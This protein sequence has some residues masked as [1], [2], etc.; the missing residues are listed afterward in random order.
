VEVVDM[1]AAGTT[2]ALSDDVKTAF[3]TFIASRVGGSSPGTTSSS[4][5]TG[6][7]RVL[8]VGDASMMLL[9]GA[10][11]VDV[12]TMS[13]GAAAS[14]LPVLQPSSFDAVVLTSG[15]ESL[16]D[17]RDV[18]RRLWQVLKPGG[19]CLACFSGAPYTPVAKSMKM[20]TTM[21]DEQ[22]IWIAGSYYQYSAGEGWENIEG[23]DLL[24]STGGASMVFDADKKKNVEGAAYVVTAQKIQIPTMGSPDFAAYNYTKGSLSGLTADMDADDRDF[25]AYRVAAE[26]ERKPADLERQRLLTSVGKLPTI[27]NILKEVKNIVIPAPV[28]AMLAVFLLE[29]WE[30]TSVQR[31]ALR[32][33]LGIDKPDDYWAALSQS[34]NAMPPREKILLLSDIIPYVGSNPNVQQLPALLQ[35]L[36]P[37]MKAKLPEAEESQLQV[38]A[39]DIAV[40]DFVIAAQPAEKIIRYIDSLNTETLQQLVADR[41]AATL[42]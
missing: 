15:I 23:Y 35:D 14:S 39:A 33:G 24:G 31:E 40:T 18:Y 4:S 6:S 13:S 19:V 25:C 16:L 2:K 12:N 29:A 22:K 30:N 42:K 5:S 38:F 3:L 32:M 36:I 7:R 9:S 34:T 21:N 10:E 8:E 11:F 41:M 1:P 26:F 27:Y 17:A 37:R 20:W 28:K